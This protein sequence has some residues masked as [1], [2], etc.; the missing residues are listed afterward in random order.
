[1]PWTGDR[2]E[3]PGADVTSMRTSISVDGCDRSRV[4][5]RIDLVI[6]R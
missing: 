4:A 6:A 1:M 2:D 5:L 3:G